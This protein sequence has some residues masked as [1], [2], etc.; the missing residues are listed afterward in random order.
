[1]DFNEAIR[2]NPKFAEAYIDRGNSFREMGQFE[3]A[4]GE[5]T[6]RFASI[7]RSPLFTTI[8]GLHFARRVNLT[9]RFTITMMPFASIPNTPKRISTAARLGD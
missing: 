4:I 2:I 3:T 9:W 8:A 1:M 7:R 5:L 6:G